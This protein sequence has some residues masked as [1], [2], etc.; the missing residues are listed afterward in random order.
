[1]IKIYAKEKLAIITDERV[2]VMETLERR[3]WLFSTAA[4]FLAGQAKV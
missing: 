3:G 1:M 4:D 2:S